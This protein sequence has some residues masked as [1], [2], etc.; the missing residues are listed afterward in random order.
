MAHAASG[1]SDGFVVVADAVAA[2]D[3]DP[4]SKVQKDDRSSQ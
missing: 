4:A 1:D 2:A 3:L